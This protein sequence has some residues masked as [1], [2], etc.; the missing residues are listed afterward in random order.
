MNWKT[1]YSISSL[2]SAAGPIAEHCETVTFDLFDTL[3]IRRI[4]D[5]D[6]VKSPVAHY[7]SEMARQR[8]ILYP[9][10]RVQELRDTIEKEQR[11][12]TG[13]EFE[14]HEACYPKFMLPVLQEVF[15]SEYGDEDLLAQVTAFELGMENRVLVARVQL[16]D[17]LK[18]LHGAGKR[19]FVV[20]DIYLPAEHLKVLVRH[21]GFLEH[22]EDVI[23]SADSFLAKASGKAF[24]LLAERYGLDY[25]KW[26]H[27]GDNPFS[28]GLRPV[29]KGI[30]ALVLRDSNEKLRRA[31]VKRYVNYSQ[32]KPLWKGRALQQLMLPLEGENADCSPLYV[33]GHNVLAP[34]LSAFVQGVAER[35]IENNIKR[36]FFFSREGWLLKQIWEQV[37][38]ILFPSADLPEVS[39]LYVS[40]M[41]LAGA[42][43]AHQGLVR[44]NADIVFLPVG[45]RDFRDVCR[46][47]S[48]E[49]EPFVSH[50]ARHKLKPD[51]PLS[52]H[53]DG[54]EPVNRLRFN[55]ILDDH[56]FQ[57]EVKRQTADAGKALE[58]YLEGEGFFDYSNVALVDIGW[59]GT[60]QRFLFDA[61]KHRRDVPACHGFLFAATRGIEYPTTRKN[62]ISGILY[63]RDHFDL[64]GSSILYARDLFE[65]ACRAPHP[66]LNGYRLTD[67]GCDL[68]FRSEEDSI[69]RAEKEQDTYFQPLQQGILA[70]ASRY[71][72]AALLM[73]YSVADLKPW[74]N[75]LL[76][77]RLA[78]PRAA[79]VED[80]RHRHHLDDFCGSKKPQAGLARKQRHLW[81]YPAKHLR[82][83]PFIR[84]KF[85]LSAIKQ[86][87]RE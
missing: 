13:L 57:Q 24:P 30:P 5:P 26:L 64:A 73:D 19:I 71:G 38:P 60:I 14:D 55:E 3:L 69:G 43:C 80:I 18:Q 27:I 81:D 22:V 25:S 11:R 72:A 31:L 79:E 4:H 36:L 58:A 29:E 15:G 76:V 68:V 66:T 2:L 6:M 34:L 35:C 82:Y 52:P 84:L 74:L 65:E 7:I 37:I 46:V 23:S 75:Y 56:E 54:F 8:G 61:V 33:Y 1:F 83:N 32:G 28:D 62:S 17:W 67:T 85:F 20:S 63:D 16:V 49:V 59:L 47:F 12:L 10:Y 87:L 45:N 70:G 77:S 21:A 9:W 40:R 53:H 86:R 42:G 50:L 51:T 39:Y 78:F 48:L 41:A 44:S